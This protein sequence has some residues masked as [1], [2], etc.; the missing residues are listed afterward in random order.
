MVKPKVG[1]VDFEGNVVGTVV[2]GIIVGHDKIVM[3]IVIENNTT[4]EDIGQRSI[5]VVEVDKVEYSQNCHFSKL[6]ANV[7]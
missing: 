3:E 1:F 5:V 6:V 7:D 4:M 2:V